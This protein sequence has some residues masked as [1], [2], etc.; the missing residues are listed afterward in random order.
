MVDRVND[1][2]PRTT[3]EA[4]RN[5]TERIRVRGVGR[6]SDEPRAMLILL[7]ERPTDDEIRSM[8]E[9]L[10]GWKL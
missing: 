9:Y 8:H 7:T 6:I 4:P 1:N 5:L 2:G 3:Y 10:R